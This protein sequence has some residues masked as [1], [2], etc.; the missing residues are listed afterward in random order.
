MSIPSRAT[1][2]P[3]VVPPAIPPPPPPLP[4]PSVEHGSQPRQEYS[5]LHIDPLLDLSKAD[6]DALGPK[7]LA[8]LPDFID[9]YA[10]ISKAV[11]ESGPMAGDALARILLE[12]PLERAIRRQVRLT[13]GGDNVMSVPVL[14]NGRLFSPRANPSIAN[15]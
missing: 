12:G 10:D 9:A 5:Q 8:K 13:S 6:S 7:V 14:V 15:T 3:I 11:D 4:N 2:L 1:L